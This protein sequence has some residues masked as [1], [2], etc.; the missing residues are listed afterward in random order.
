VHKGRWTH[1]IIVASISWCCLFAALHVFWALGG[2]AGLATSA[3]T[4]LA[5]ERPAW[6]VAVGL[7]G[8]AVVLLIGAAV[9]YAFSS[10]VLSGRVAR[11]LGVLIVLAG[12]VMVAR[13][14][15]VEAAL[16]FDLG[17]VRSEV[18][19]AQTRWSLALWDPWFI[20]GG[21][22]VAATGV[23]GLDKLADARSNSPA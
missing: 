20:A 1:W 17:G 6:F 22:L 13:G 18:G 10:G 2:S 15:L 7:W 19:P 8:V 12:L 3:G 5:A 14:V 16:V 21:A 23:S 9:L 4:E 11:V